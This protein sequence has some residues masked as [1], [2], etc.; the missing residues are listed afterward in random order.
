MEGDAQTCFEAERPDNETTPLITVIIAVFN[1]VQTLE[2]AILS[3]IEQSYKKLELIIIDGGS[4]DGTQNIIRKYEAKIAYWVSEPD[5]GVFDAW[6][7]GVAI[8]TGEWIAFIGS[9]DYYLDGALNSYA[10]LI[11]EG[12]N[13]NLEYVSSMVNLV[14]GPT[15]LRTLGLKWNW[16]A[17][18]KA[19]IVAHVGS[20][21]NRKLFETYGPYDTSY[22]ICGDYE[23][24]LRAKG[25][26]SAGFLN[27]VTA[28][29]RVGGISDNS[30][31]FSESERAKVFTGGKA[32]FVAR[33]EKLLVIIKYEFHRYRRSGRKQIK[34]TNLS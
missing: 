10:E 25:D 8:A 4:N 20:L 2:Q 34:S 22:K 28:N 30:L 6:N 26:L 14:S 5:N 19:M 31:A 29:M 32:R 21:H 1:G 18:R 24:L 11:I 15:V 16:K 7:K 3:V 9:D 17:F 12:Q 23:F 33:L 27:R 13:K